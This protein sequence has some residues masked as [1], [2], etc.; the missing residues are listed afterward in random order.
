LQPQSTHG[1]VKNY[2]RYA[3][4]ASGLFDGTYSEPK[5]LIPFGHVDDKRIIVGH[6]VSY[7]RA[8]IKEEYRFKPSAF[9]FVDTM[10]LHCAI[11]GL[12]LMTLMTVRS[13]ALHG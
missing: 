6:N 12:R 1:N 8:R 13:N 5:E 3:W 2:G 10:S 7:D 9:G 4:C 11:G